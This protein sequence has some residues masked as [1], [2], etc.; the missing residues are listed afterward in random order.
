MQ[1][2]SLPPPHRLVLA[3]IPRRTRWQQESP[4]TRCLRQTT[5]PSSIKKRKYPEHDFAIERSGAVEGKRSYP[6]R[7][8]LKAAAFTRAL[9][10]DGQSAENAGALTVLGVDRKRIIVWL[11]DE[12]KLNSKINANPKLSKDK[13]A[14]AGVTASTAD[15]EEALDD[16]INEQHTQHRGC[17][18]KEVMNK[19]LELKPI[20]PGG[21]PATARPEEALA[22][23]DK[24][25]CWYQRFRKRRGFSIHRRTSVG[26]VDEAAQGS[27]GPH[28]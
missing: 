23:S 12:E 18:S 14:H 16:Y 8:K 1:A 19:L 21:L 28:G 2:R 27:R 26:D 15:I 9:C 10:A 4:S 13:Q 11:H 25:K 17:G 22:F 5:P 7:F 6:I 3:V 24:F 20:A